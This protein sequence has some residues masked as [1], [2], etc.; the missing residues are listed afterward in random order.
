MKAGSLQHE[1]VVA[2]LCMAAM[3][4]SPALPTRAATCLE[5]VRDLADRYH[6]VTAPP[7]AGQPAPITPN[8]LSR[9]GGVIEPPPVDDKS[10]IT[11]PQPSQGAMP[12][13]PD[14]S[15][16]RPQS[17]A[18]PEASKAEAVER[19]SLQALLVAA[20]AQAERGEEAQCLDR[21]NKAHELLARKQ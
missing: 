7:S 20:R 6:V 18:E 17:K 11:P 1:A 3:V 14:V 19:A 5:Q 2:S 15:R 16:D 9:S 12:T 21:L 10:V 8:Q 13:L 4:L